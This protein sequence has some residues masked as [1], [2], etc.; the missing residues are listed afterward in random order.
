VISC[1]SCPCSIKYHLSLTYQ[2]YPNRSIPRRTSS[3]DILYSLL[4]VESLTTRNPVDRSGNHSQGCIPLS[5]AQSPNV[6]PF[7]YQYIRLASSMHGHKHR[8]SCAGGGDSDS[9]AF[10]IESVN[11]TPQADCETSSK[12]HGAAAIN[13]RYQYLPISS[14]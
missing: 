3:Y 1:I 8:T 10:A 13:D 4:T 14:N 11:D 5:T 7:Q 12:L 6:F 2:R 9:H